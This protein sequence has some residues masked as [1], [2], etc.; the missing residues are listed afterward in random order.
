VPEFC[1][2]GILGS[3]LALLGLNTYDAAVNGNFAPL[4]SQATGL[5]ADPLG[6]NAS[7]KLRTIENLGSKFGHEIDRATGL[8]SQ[9]IA[10]KTVCTIFGDK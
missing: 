2:P 10:E 4:A 6:L 9:K 3:Q 1:V 7:R 5:A 8:G